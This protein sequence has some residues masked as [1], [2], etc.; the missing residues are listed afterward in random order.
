MPRTGAGV[1]FRAAPAPGAYD[2][3]GRADSE[4]VERAAAGDRDAFAALYDRYATPVHYLLRRMLRDD[5]EAS[6]A[7]Q[8]TFIAAVDRPHQLRD[9]SRFRPW[10]YAIARRRAYLVTSR[11]RRF[12]T[13]EDDD[14]I[15]AEPDYA[16]GLAA[17]ELRARIEG[18]A[19]GL[20]DKDRLLL[21]LQVRH[22]LEGQDLADA[23]GVDRGNVHV[24]AHRLRER[25]ERSLG[26]LVLVR[27]GQAACAALSSVVGADAADGQ[28]TPALRKRVSRHADDCATCTDERDR[29][30]RREA[31]LG[32]VP[33]APAPAG[34]REAVLERVQLCSHS[35]A[36]WDGPDGFPP[37]AARA[38][39]RRHQIGRA[40]V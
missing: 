7:L 29:R 5:H 12:E 18:A 33:F 17:A 23:V 21:D 35:G 30:L 3:R 22:G 36:P 10:V 19:G 38:G 39:R 34:A 4:L 25:L 16:E 9:P 1:A 6:D 27:H 24:M 37:G 15:S 20:D 8:D 31:L 13:L 11:Q 26:A 32:L 40:H 28:L 2:P 14:G